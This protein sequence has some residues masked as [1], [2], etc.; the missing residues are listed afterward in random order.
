M[1]K[2]YQSFLEKEKQQQHNHFNNK[3]VNQK[4]NKKQENRT[5]SPQV[6]NPD[7]KKNAH[8]KHAHQFTNFNK[9]SSGGAK[10]RIIPLGGLGEIGKN[11]MILEYSDLSAPNGGDI[12]IVDCGLMF[13]GGEMPGIDFVIPNIEYL[14]RNRN[15]IRG[16]IVTHG[17]EDHAGAIPYIWPKLSTPIY[18]AKLTAAMIES[19]FKEFSLSRPHLNIVEPG[20]S[21]QLGI[22]KINTFALSHTIPDELG[23]LIET[24]VGNLAFISDFRLDKDDPKEKQFLEDLTNIG[25]KGVFCLMMD[26]TN[27]EVEGQSVSE[28]KI[29]DTIESI[30]GKA[31]GRVI[32]TSFASSLPRI[33]SVVEA[34]VKYHRKVAVSGRS[35][36]NSIKI[37]MRL[38]YLKIPHGVLIEANQ[39]NHFRKEELII[40][41]TG[42]QG[43]EYAALVRMSSGEH[44]QIKIEP[45]DTVIVSASAVP[46]NERAIARTIDNLFREGAE[47]I[48]GGERAEVHASGH[49][50]GEDLKTVMKLLRPKYFIPVHGEFRHLV[51]HA[52]LARKMG[53]DPKNIF[54][55]ENGE[56]VEFDKT[57][58]KIISSKAP[59]GY[60]LVDGLGVGD[61]GN[62]V[63]RDRQAMAKDGIFV[64]ILTIDH[65]TGKIV[66][67]PD[68]ISRGFVYM[69]AREDLIQKSRQEVRRMFSHHNEK[70]PAD[71]DYIRREI[72]DEMGEFLY[73]E[74]QRRPMIIPVIIEV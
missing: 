61:V 19:K 73:K 14:E 55:I 39:I 43:E 13:P 66:T 24:P 60:V 21:F 47:V 18:T 64:V 37:A 63:L 58:G 1:D 12:V 67:S 26:S 11:M 54:V 72:R 59:S 38:G 34:A 9:P 51:R 31:S 5:N 71:W 27:A 44:R 22:F 35:M 68:I 8:G 30:I 57:S 40:L 42:S 49:A 53:I 74:T 2:Q 69:R 41:C 65:A 48:Y 25:N 3:N 10:F 45:G 28:V 17:H 50:K 36:E 7:H 16:M 4:F 70:N 15:K 6:F 29:K 62:I 20:Q 32:V 46:G 33:Q 23:L 56:I 52:Q